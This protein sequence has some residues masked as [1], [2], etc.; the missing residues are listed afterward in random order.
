MEKKQENG[1][2]LT[3]K[4]II[5]LQGQADIGKTG[6]IMALIKRLLHKST[7]KPQWNYPETAPETLSNLEPPINVEVWIHDLHI[8]LDTEGDEAESLKSNLTLLVRHNCD[9][10]FCTCRSK[11]KTPKVVMDIARRQNYSLICTSPYT[12]KTR[13]GPEDETTMH[14]KKAEHLEILI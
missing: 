5:C 14:E 6:T 4:R 1:F 12:I 9:L 11:G 10:I 2:S 3:G 13:H 7:Q 8:G